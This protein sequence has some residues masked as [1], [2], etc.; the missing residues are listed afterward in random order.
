MRLSLISTAW[1][2]VGLVAATPTSATSASFSGE[3][4]FGLGFLIERLAGYLP[5]DD[6]VMR[7]SGPSIC[8]LLDQFSFIVTPDIPLLDDADAAQNWIDDAFLGLDWLP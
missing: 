7:S 1:I 5:E 6:D 4:E 3:T 8:G 2:V